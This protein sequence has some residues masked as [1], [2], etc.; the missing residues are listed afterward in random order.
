M[1]NISSDVI[2]GYNDTIKSLQEQID[3]SGSTVGDLQ[4]QLTTLKTAAE[5]AHSKVTSP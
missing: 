5:A 2:R 3:K 4:T 1:V